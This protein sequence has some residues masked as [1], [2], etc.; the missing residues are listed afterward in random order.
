LW[1]IFSTFSCF[2]PGNWEAKELDKSLLITYE[3]LDEKRPGKK[4]LFEDLSKINYLDARPAPLFNGDVPL[5][6]P[7]EGATGNHLKGAKNVPLSAVVGESGIKSKEGIEKALKD[8][9]FDS[10][11]PTVVAC[12]G[13]VQASLLSLVLK[14]VGR[15]SR[16]YNGS[17][18]EI[19]LRAPQMISEKKDSP[20]KSGWIHSICPICLVFIF[21]ISLSNPLICRL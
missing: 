18:Y 3:E 14:R 4:S 1:I 2:Q 12:N 7:A 21:A 9:E 10:S 19:A 6:I 15:K 11:L 13:G 20:R 17:M 5:D 16:V 8:A